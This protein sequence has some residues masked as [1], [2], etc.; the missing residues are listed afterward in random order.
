LEER[1]W[2]RE[3]GTWRRGKEWRRGNEDVEERREWRRIDEGMEE[4][5]RVLLR[6]VPETEGR[7]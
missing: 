4:R 5:G 1:T 2:T 7:Q 3:K 6:R